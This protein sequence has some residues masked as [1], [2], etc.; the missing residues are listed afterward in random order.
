MRRSFIFTLAAVPLVLAPAAHAD[1]VKRTAAGADPAA[2]QAAVDAFRADVGGNN[3]GGGGGPQASG[4]REINWDGV[5]DAFADPNPFPGGFFNARGLALATPGTGFSVSANANLQPPTPV[6]F[7]SQEFQ[8]FTPQRL[9]RPVGSGVTDNLFF[10]P[11]TATQA[12]TNA[13][14]VVFTDVDQ[15]G[16][17]KLEYFDP[18][19][20][21]IDTVVAPAAPSGLSFAGETFNAGERVARVRITTGSGAVAD[22]ATEDAVVM[23]D[24]LYGEPQVVVPAPP[25]PTPDPGTP[26]PAEDTTAPRLALLRLHSAAIRYAIVSDE[27]GTYKLKLALSAGQAK[28]LK[29]KQR[30]LLTTGNRTLRAGSNTVSLRFSKSLTT[31]LRKTRIKPLLTVS[32][33][34]AA[35]N[36]A[37]K[38]QRVAV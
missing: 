3:N 31:K 37:G 17:A 18:Y 10:L 20:K 16:S 28:K 25:A 29:L 15:V 24:F 5:G 2:I 13:M 33:A 34:D 1:G 22:T 11:G 35:G 30:T 4:R 26:P 19:G 6:R 21:L 23:D 12:T 9:F 7:G 27:P 32:A 14:G 8:T 38:S 36:R